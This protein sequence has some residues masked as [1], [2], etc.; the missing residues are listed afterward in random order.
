MI[1]FFES[2]AMERHTLLPPIH[3]WQGNEPDIHAPFLFSAWGDPDGS[4]RWSRWALRTFY[5]EHRYRI[6]RTR[7]LL[8][9]LDAA[10]GYDSQRHARRFPSLY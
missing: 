10:S 5:R 3:Y 8:D 1:T 6:A 4:A 9:S 2:S 7:K